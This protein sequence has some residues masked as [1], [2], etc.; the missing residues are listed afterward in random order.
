M[1]NLRTDK[2][3][4]GCVCD[5]ISLFLYVFIFLSLLCLYRM[6]KIPKSDQSQK[7]STKYKSDK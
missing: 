6:A 5:S 3:I 4:S 1:S 2:I 7:I